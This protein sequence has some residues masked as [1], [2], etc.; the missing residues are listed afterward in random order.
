MLVE[1]NDF[2]GALCA[3]SAL[4]FIFIFNSWW[5]VCGENWLYFQIFSHAVNAF[6]KKMPCSVTRWW[7]KQNKEG[8]ISLN[9]CFRYR[10]PFISIFY[11][12]FP[13][14]C[15]LSIHRY[16]TPSVLV[17]EQLQRLLRWAVW[18]FIHSLNSNNSIHYRRLII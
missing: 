7:A 13:F 3:N 11:L 1:K 4:Y 14:W 9:C 2:W 12:K 6:K 5:V 17:L 16:C 8:N 10:L 15:I 18:S